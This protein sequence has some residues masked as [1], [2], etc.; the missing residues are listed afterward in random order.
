MKNEIKKRAII[1][2]RVSSDDQV[3]GGSLNYQETTLKKYCE[4]KG[5]EVVETYREDFSAKTFKRPEITKICNKYLRK[6][7]EIEA[8][9][10][11]VLRW[12]RFTRDASDG[13]EFIS[14]FREYDI[15]VN[16][17]EE[18]ID[19][20][21]AE[22]KIMLAIYLTMAEVDNDKRSKA[23][24]DGIHQALAEGKSAGHAPYGYD[25]R[26]NGK[27]NSW[28]EVNKSESAFVIEAFK[29][30]AH[31]VEVP[32]L[33][34]RDLRK[35]G[36]KIGETSFFRMLRSIYYIGKIRVPAYG[37]YPEMIVDGKHQPI[38]DINTF[39]I[40]Q[41]YL[42]RLEKKSIE[43]K[44]IPDSAFYMRAFMR[45][46][47]CGSPVYGSFSKGRNRKYAYYHCN[48]CN[49]FR[50]SAD[51]ANENMYRFLDNIKP[52]KAIVALYK[53][54][55]LDLK[56]SDNKEKQDNIKAMKKNLESINEKINK[57]QEK[58]LEGIIDDD[59]FKS[60]NS[61]LNKEKQDLDMNLSE[62]KEKTIAKD[63]D[64]KF[65]YALNF[66]EKM[67]SC[68]SVAPI[69]IKLHILGSIFSEKIVF[70]NLNP[71]T[72][73]LSPLIALITGKT[74]ICKGVK[75]EGLSKFNESP[76]KGGWWVSNPRPPEPQ[77]G[78]LA[79]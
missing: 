50:I 48:Y 23:T 58:W 78:A 34:F 32:T 14:K 15:E 77:S 76:A 35:K 4:S 19:Y 36:M 21:I 53:E 71:R 16:A 5:I 54:I 28:V 67:G 37:D 11:L 29:R 27:H 57:V 45:C 70:E 56:Q 42:N 18:H 3:K 10:L 41:K 72:A 12:N 46:P 79:N 24:K 30:V 52:D 75:K 61:R 74:E 59:T 51:K 73:E 60:M 26:S 22:S 40:V 39:A 13:W 55:L 44:K 69:E 1:Y 49:Q 25:N 9:Y 38:I 2:C 43:V 62:L 66:I 17:I 65:E 63:A 47:V 7:K 6:K 20:S 33:V 68:I 64:I 31:G 8:D